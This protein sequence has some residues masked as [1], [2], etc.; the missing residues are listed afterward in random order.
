MAA[1][2]YLVVAALDDVVPPCHKTKLQPQGR[3][4]DGAVTVVRRPGDFW[5]TFLGKERGDKP[6]SNHNKGELSVGGGLEVVEHAALEH[7]DSI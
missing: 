6:E 7:I 4:K 3:L 2:T 5:A 1:S